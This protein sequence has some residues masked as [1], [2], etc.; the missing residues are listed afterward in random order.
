MD[1]MIRKIEIEIAR[2]NAKRASSYMTFE[3]AADRGI[4]Y[5]RRVLGAD[6]AVGLPTPGADDCQDA[7]RAMVRANSR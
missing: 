6:Y 7:Y 2:Q 4:R 5:A 1:A 3:A